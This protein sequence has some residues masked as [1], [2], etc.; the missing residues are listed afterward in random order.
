VDLHGENHP[1]VNIHFGADALVHSVRDELSMELRF[2]VKGLVKGFTYLL[3]VRE[4]ASGTIIQTHDK[5]VR[6]DS[7]HTMQSL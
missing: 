6:F 7:E 2:T 5:I 4:E 3:V 1:P